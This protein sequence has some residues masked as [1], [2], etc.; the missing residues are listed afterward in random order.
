MIATG[1]NQFEEANGKQ[2]KIL[3]I[4]KPKV[5]VEQDSGKE[6][7]SGATKGSGLSV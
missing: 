6:L 7:E 5:K 2:G 3:E 4:K 1:R